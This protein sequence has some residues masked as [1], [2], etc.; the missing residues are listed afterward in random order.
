M[1][2][3]YELSQDLL[4][5]QIELLE[6]KYGGIRARIAAITIQRAFR[7][8]TMVKKFASI[9]AMAKAEKRLS[10]R[11]NQQSQSQQPPNN[12]QIQSEYNDDMLSSSYVS[13]VNVSVGSE[14]DVSI[15]SGNAGR[16]VTVTPSNNSR[17]APIRSMSLRE[18]RSMDA[19]PIP[20]SQSGNSSPM[21]VTTG[22]GA[23]WTKSSQHSHPHVNLMHAEQHYHSSPIQGYQQMQQV[24]P[25][26]N[27]QTI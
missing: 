27:K 9:T 14:T 6:R 5:K 24:K 20:R 22:A 17:V 11:Y 19:S 8:Y 10:R 3:R 23:A 7:H 16:I 1:I 26:N 15:N 25:I 21:Q 13:N 18:R 4:D 2:G 12:N